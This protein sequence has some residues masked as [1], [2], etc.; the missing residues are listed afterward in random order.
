M[1]VNAICFLGNH[2]GGV[3]FFN[4]TNVGNVGVLEFE[5]SLVATIY[6]NPVTD[7]LHINLTTDNIENNT[8]TLIDVLG[9]EV[10]KTKSYN[11]TLTIDVSVLSK[12]IYFLSIQN[13][14]LRTVFNSKLIVD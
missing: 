11:K 12:G 8:I 10:Y 14:S 9:K 7:K 6:P 13:E 3:A 2:A 1:M 5:N 4:S